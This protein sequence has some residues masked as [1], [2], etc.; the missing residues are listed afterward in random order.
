MAELGHVVLYVKD[1]QTSLKFYRDLIG[2]QAKGSVFNGRAVMLTGGRTHHELMLLEVGE[3]LG[4]LSGHRLGLY[5]I[6]WKIGDSLQQL[7][8]MRDRIEKAGYQIT[9]MSDHWISRSIYLL[10]PDANEV[11]VFVDDPD[12]DWQNDDRWIEQPVKQLN[13]D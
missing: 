4:P 12:Y 11:E 7:R 13:L 2:L 1:L 6:G 5:H 9:G 3:A 8:E 10:D